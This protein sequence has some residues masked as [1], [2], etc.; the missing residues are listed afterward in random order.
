MLRSGF[1][2]PKQL[3]L[4]LQH[5]YSIVVVRLTVC[6]KLWATGGLPGIQPGLLTCCFKIAAS[7]LET[8]S[9]VVVCKKCQYTPGFCWM[10]LKF[11][12]GKRKL[13][14]PAMEE[15]NRQ[16]TENKLGSVKEVG[17]HLWAV[18]TSSLPFPSACH[19][20]AAEDL[21]VV[22]EL[23][24]TS[25]W[26]RI[27][28][29]SRKSRKI[30]KNHSEMLCSASW[31]VFNCILSYVRFSSEDDPFLLYATLHSGNH[32]KFITKDLLRDH[33]ACLADAKTQRL[34]FKWQRGHQLAIISRFP[35]SKITFQVW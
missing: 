19:H 2:E 32:C 27:Q 12:W 11:G 35:G 23:Q 3:L 34:F 25:H 30:R 31:S 33:K 14:Y 1:P 26:W 8:A 5:M 15:A 13:V 18:R 21:W 22:L 20:M 29:R 28:K 16:S 24:W 6:W 17:E 10:F 7:A 9:Y 4:F